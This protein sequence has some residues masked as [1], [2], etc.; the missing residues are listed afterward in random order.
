MEEAE[1]AFQKATALSPSLSIAR[2]ELGNIYFEQGNFLKAQTTW[3]PVLTSEQIDMP[4]HLVNLGA[5]Y[6][7]SG[8]FNLAIQAW[9][10]AGELK[11]E[12]PQIRYNVALAYCRLGKY[13]EAADE[14]KELLRFK[15]DDQAASVLLGRIEALL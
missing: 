7:R 15:P 6:F 12:D 2:L 11:K 3:Q 4:T 5:Q 9:R 14:L 1:Q 8:D 13:T 10:K